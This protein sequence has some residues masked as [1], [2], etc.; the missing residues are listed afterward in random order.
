MARGYHSRDLTPEQLQRKL[1]T[2][3]YLMPR[4]V[5]AALKHGTRVLRDEMRRRY[6]AA[7]LHR[8]TGDLFESIKVLNVDLRGRRVSAAAGV[9]IVKGHSQ[10]YKAVA[11]EL[12]LRV[13]HGVVLPKR[14]FVAPTKKAKLQRVRE[15]ILDE[16]ITGYRR[17]G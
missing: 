9:G 1:N 16:L 11:H 3:T 15:L 7:G 5:K 8:R 10:V 13:G 6:F 17:A 12:G 2:F 4:Y 14:A